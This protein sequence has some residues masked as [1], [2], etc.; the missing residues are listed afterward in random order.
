MTSR[1]INAYVC[2][3]GF[4]DGV[5]L[6]HQ[7]LLSIVKD[8]KEKNKIRSIIYTFDKVAKI[9]GGL[10]YP[11]EEKVKLLNNS[12]VDKVVMLDFNKIKNLTSEEF[13]E[14]FILK[15]NVS[16]IVSG[17]DFRFGRNATGD[18]KLLNSLC[19]ENKIVSVI[20]EDYY[21]SFDNICYSIS[22]SLIR[23]KILESNFL[24]VEKLLGRSYYIKGTVTK[25]NKVG[26]KIGIPTINILPDRNLVL[27][28]G[29]ITGFCRINNINFAAV[30]NFGV[31]PTVD[32][33]NFMIEIHVINAKVEVS[34][35]DI[36]EFR[37]IKKIR[38]EKKFSNLSQLRKQVLNDIRVAQSL[39]NKS[40]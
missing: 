22:S 26:T 10:I 1:R 36:V 4:F 16:I 20:V 6:G 31:R 34:D 27:P 14:H 18:V 17:E 7:M 28:Q 8:I 5:H 24:L 23:E 35:K 3:I 38:D 30:A 15:K 25:G 9:K 19:K 32:G 39:L 2:T 12:G 11:V 37:P 29:V 21:L 40:F 13:F 33:K